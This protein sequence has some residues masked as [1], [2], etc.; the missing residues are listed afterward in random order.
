MYSLYYD[1]LISICLEISHLL[2]L[3]MVYMLLE[4]SIFSFL[5][6]KIWH[7]K[8]KEVKE[9]KQPNWITG[10]GYYFSRNT[11]KQRLSYKI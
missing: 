10:M 2:L 5:L 4:T 3:M 11:T 1:I 9:H 7:L 6:E 8:I